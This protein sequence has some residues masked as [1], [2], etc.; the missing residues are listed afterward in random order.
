MTKLARFFQH[1]LAWIVGVLLIAFLVR[2]P[3]LAEPP[4]TIFDEAIYA[5]YT[6][7]HVEQV[8]YIDIHP[9][10]ARSVFATIAGEF[11]FLTTAIEWRT[12][13]A[14]SDFP[15]LPLRM[16]MVFFGTLAPVL[17]YAIGRGFGLA[18]PWAGIAGVLAAIEPGYI[19]FSRMMVPDML[20]IA[21]GFA[22][23]ATTLAINVHGSHRFRYAL[24]IA[25]GIL[26]GVAVSMKWTALGLLAAGVFALFLSRRFLLSLLICA[27]AC[28]VYVAAFFWFFSAFP[29]GGLIEQIVPSLFRNTDVSIT[30]PPSG[31]AMLDAIADLHR[32][33]YAGQSG[34]SFIHESA[35]GDSPITWAVGATRFPLW[36]SDDKTRQITLLANPLLWTVALLLFVLALVAHGTKNAATPSADIPGFGPRHLPLVL[37]AGYLGNYVPFFFIERPM[38]LYHY[39]IALAFLYLALPW[40]LRE[41][42]RILSRVIPSHSLRASIAGMFVI[43]IVLI[44]VTLISFTYGI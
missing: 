42:W 2:I 19:I 13:A 31:G 9:P 10:I 18:P 4:R 26:F 17:L 44:H 12:N 32:V 20:L 37:A 23:L 7:R 1:D 30:L 11:P 29:M 33:M 27:V 41:G 15:Y 21:F 8:P 6:I 22:G 24:A 43:A 35:A 39:F 25:A 34:E 28:S 38:Y 14:F 16:L 3:H 40:G 36:L 5:N